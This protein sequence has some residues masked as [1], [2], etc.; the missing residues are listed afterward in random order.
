M[1]NKPPP[2]GIRKSI[3]DTLLLALMPLH[4]APS[5]KRQP[6]PASRAIFQ[7]KLTVR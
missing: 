7:F 3:G 5:S 6:H 4:P 1:W 2:P